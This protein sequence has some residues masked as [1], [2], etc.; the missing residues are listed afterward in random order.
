MT[1]NV[2]SEPSASTFRV[3]GMQVGATVPGFYAGLGME[4]WASSMLGLHYPEIHAKPAVV[5]TNYLHMFCNYS[6][7]KFYLKRE[8]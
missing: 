5:F 2:S 4:P 3:L 7:G 8:F 1:L 6:P